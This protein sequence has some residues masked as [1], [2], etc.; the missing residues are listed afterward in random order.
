M[1]T[2]SGGRRRAFK[3]RHHTPMGHGGKLAVIFVCIA[4]LLFVLAVML[5]NYLRGLAEDIIE[6]TTDSQSTE[7]MVYYANPPADMIARGIIFG[8]DYVQSDDTSAITEDITDE[9]TSENTAETLYEPDPIKYDAVSVKL[10]EKDTESGEM[11][12]AYTSPIA[13]GYSID[14]IG[15]T[16]LYSGLDL[17]ASNWGE[18]TRICGIFE[19]DYLN[20]PEDVRAITRAYETALVCELVEAGLEEILLLGFSNNAEEGL[21]FI[22]DVYE[23]KGRGTAI[24]LGFP[25]DF[26]NSPDADQ[27]LGEIA[28]KCGFLALDLSSEKIP[29]LM[30]AESV[31][32]DRVSRTG[33]ICREYS[34]RVLL[35]CGDSP[36]CDSQ[37]RAAME[38]GSKNIMT[39]LGI[40]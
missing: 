1:S 4:L 9:I 7:E 8:M 5:G 33:A 2:V 37:T 17:I 19:V 24:G 31:I 22:S 10:R 38:S 28:K 25:F 3:S 15:E 11:R 26:V 16:D 21:S 39:V 40:K 12:L 30:D 27:K 13:S 35:G 14:V 6:N 20:S 32:S 36:D 18:R 34:I 23:Q 29:A